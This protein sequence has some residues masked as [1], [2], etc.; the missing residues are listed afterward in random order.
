MKALRRL[1]LVVTA[2]LVACGS[3]LPKLRQQLDDTDPDVR[4]TALKALA[5][6]KDDVAVP[7]IVELLA[8]T[9]PDVRKEAARALGKIGDTAA[10]EPLAQTY[11]KEQR[12]D[13]ADAVVRALVELGGASVQPLIRLTRSFIP[14][15]RAGAARALGKL[16]STAAVDP[17]I[18]LLERDREPDVRIAAVYALRAIGDRRG[19]DAI[20]RAAQ[21]TDQDVEFAVEK[22]LSG[23]G[24]EDQMDR[25]RRVL[26]LGR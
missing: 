17:L 10:V 9:V 11:E 19:M 6:V 20:A 4:I 16:H 8:D 23:G 13:V 24:Y 12:E 26:R 22:A 3:K 1:A 15:V 14:N 18:G 2:V 7:K 5:D 21:D 25:V